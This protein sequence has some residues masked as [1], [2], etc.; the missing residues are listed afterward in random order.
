[1]R[2]LKTTKENLGSSSPLTM[3]NSAFMYYL[4]TVY[5]LYVLFSFFVGS[6]QAT[7]SNNRKIFSVPYPSRPP[8]GY[9]GFPAAV[10]AR[11]PDAIDPTA[12]GRLREGGQHSPFNPIQRGFFTKKPPKKK[13]NPQKLETSK[14]GPPNSE[15]IRKPTKIPKRKFTHNNSKKTRYNNPTKSPPSK[16]FIIHPA[17]L[18]YQL[19]VEAFKSP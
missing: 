8:N 3:G 15:N 14:K 1:M 2:A 10:P 12:P 7:Y 4:L 9:L 6:L 5:L 13:K 19:K 16:Q 17:N 18:S 11:S